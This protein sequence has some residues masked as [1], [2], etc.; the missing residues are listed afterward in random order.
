[1]PH[2]VHSANGEFAE[3][4]D[5]AS[6]T[7]SADSPGKDAGGITSALD[8]SSGGE[9]IKSN[10][11][12]LESARLWETFELDGA[13]LG[14]LQQHGFVVLPRF[15]SEVDRCSLLQAF[16]AD[17]ETRNLADT[18]LY[19][20]KQDTEQ[21]LRPRVVKMESV[22]FGKGEYTYLKEPLPQPLGEIREYMY[23]VLAPLANADLELHRREVAPKPFTVEEFPPRLDQF[24]ELCRNADP[25]QCLPTCLVNR[26]NEGGH[27][28]PHRDI[29]GNVSFPFQLLTVLT[30]ADQDFTGGQFYVQ[31]EKNDDSH[32]QHVRLHPGDVLI[33]RSSK[34]HG[35][36]P[37]TSGRRVACGLQFHLSKS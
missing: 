10:D 22:K 24:W 28:L 1:M 29:Y 33:F 13:Q 3:T 7:A 12:A 18:K 21:K 19:K 17:I 36:E 37:V 15:L 32:R 34:W 35:S 25:P 2:A 30:V 31:R 9:K 4:V 5:T 14:A 8:D 16:D 26:Y 20:G 6:A 27:N 23:A 11:L